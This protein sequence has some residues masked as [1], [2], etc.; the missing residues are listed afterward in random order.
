MTH[1]AGM[2]SGVGWKG[3]AVDSGYAVVVGALI[4]LAG[5]VIGAIVTIT[6][7]RINDK[8]AQ[9]KEVQEE[10]RHAEQMALDRRRADI[11][12]RR[13][14]FATYLTTCYT[15]Y[16]AILE[17]R[18]QRRRGVLPLD[19]DGTRFDDQVKGL[20]AAR[21][22]V[23]LLGSPLAVEAAYQA[24]TGL[25]NASSQFEKVSDEQFDSYIVVA[26]EAIEAAAAAA[27]G[28]LRST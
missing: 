11:D 20:L 13:E 1:Y 14:A 3:E 24:F 7:A 9:R 18:D 12:S 5:A 15:Y 19:P 28:E 6:I 17:A 16:I 23:A 21:A 8:A 4:G 26:V 2:S 22:P 27:N 25:V 10:A